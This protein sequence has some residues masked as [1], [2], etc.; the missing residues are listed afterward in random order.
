MTPKQLLVPLVLG[1]LLL[2]GCKKETTGDK[3]E[4]AAKKAG[5]KIEKAADKVE[6]AV[7]KDG[8]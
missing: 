3:I 7:K 1:A 6:D 8:K 5:D 4:G 2:G